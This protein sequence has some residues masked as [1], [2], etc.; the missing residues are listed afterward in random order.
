MQTMP[1]N[2]ET[3]SGTL[4]RICVSQSKRTAADWQCTLARCVAYTTLIYFQ[5]RHRSY[6]FTS[7]SCRLKTRLWQ[8][9]GLQLE[10]SLVWPE[11]LLIKVSCNWWGYPPS[12]RW[13][14]P[15]PSVK[16]YPLLARWGTYPPSAGW[17]GGTPRQ[18]GGVNP[19]PQM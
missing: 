14:Y 11:A 16:L 17:D 18:P 4:Q 12:A 5:S 13:G 1:S 3:F 9:Y 10:Y 19:P 2:L 6:R 8:P 7:T 15:P